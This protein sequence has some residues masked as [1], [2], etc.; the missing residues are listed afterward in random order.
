MDL[1]AVLNEAGMSFPA[2]I[3]FRA[4]VMVAVEG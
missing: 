3:G 1:D 4:E 2:E